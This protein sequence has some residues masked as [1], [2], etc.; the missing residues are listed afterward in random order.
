MR[1]RLL[2][3][4]AAPEMMAERILKPRNFPFFHAEDFRE[5]GIPEA[6]SNRYGAPLPG[7]AR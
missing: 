1:D 4:G 5:D 7:F 3:D 2:D 6:E